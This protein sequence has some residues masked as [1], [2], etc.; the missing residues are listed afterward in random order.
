[1]F[2]IFFSF[3]SGHQIVRLSQHGWI[4]SPM[5]DVNPDTCGDFLSMDAGFN[6]SSIDFG[7][8]LEVSE[9]FGL[10]IREARERLAQISGTVKSSR[11]RTAKAQ[12]LSRS[13][14]ERMTPAFGD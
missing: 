10:G 1:M 5:Y 4:L 2:T 3:R 12:G 8:A 6:Y 7:L 11:K 14:L 9:Y 13:E